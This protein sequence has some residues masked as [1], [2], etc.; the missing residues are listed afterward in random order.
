MYRR[1]CLHGLG[2]GLIGL[3]SHANSRSATQEFNG[4]AL[5]INKDRAEKVVDVARGI[6]IVESQVD[7]STGNAARDRAL[8]RAL[9]RMSQLFQ[10]RPSFGFIDDGAQPNAFATDEVRI[11]STWGSVLFGRRL[12]QE[13]NDRFDDGGM[14]V[15]CV[16]AHEFA[17][18]AQYRTKS[19]S[20]LV[21]AG[22]KSKRAELHADLLAG[23]YLGMR[24]AQ[25]PSLQLRSAGVH[26]FEIGDFEFNHRDHHGTPAERVE[27]AERGFALAKGKDSS[28]RNAFDV[29]LGWVLEKHAS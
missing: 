14:A 1:Q 4:C 8:G 26:L 12:F 17:H 11:A 21:G 7:S 16:M 5:L 3:C 28:F 10:E 27:A 20:S 13:L 29:G 23:Y 19:Y 25:V 22:R 9:V 18:I 15:L 2:L 24:K 6:G